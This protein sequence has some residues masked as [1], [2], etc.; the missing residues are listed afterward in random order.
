SDHTERKLVMAKN[1]DTRDFNFTRTGFGFATKAAASVSSALPGDHEVRVERFNAFTGSPTA[2]RSVN[3]GSAFGLAPG[4][5]APDQSFITRAIDHVRIAAPAL[6]F[7][8]AEVPEF[9]PDGGVK[10]TSTGERVVNLRQQYRG[11]PVFQMERAV[12][13]DARGAIQNVTG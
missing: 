6:G 5:G 9:A 1:L 7:A 4:L 11:I 13:F 3:A 2:L 10:E 12:L 8:P